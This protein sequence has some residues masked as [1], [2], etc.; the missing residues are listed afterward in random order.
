[1]NAAQDDPCL[2]GCS[3]DNSR[4]PIGILAHDL[5][6]AGKL[7]AVLPVL[8]KRWRADTLNCLGSLNGV[9]GQQNESAALC[10][11]CGLTSRICAA[12]ECVP[13]RARVIA[14][15][16]FQRALMGCMLM[17]CVGGLEMT[18]MLRPAAILVL[19]A[20]LSSSGCASSSWHLRKESD[21]Q[22]YERF[23]RRGNFGPRDT[24][25]GLGH[26]P[27]IQPLIQL[28][29]QSFLTSS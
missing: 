12:D 1:M 27:L 25:G 3:F 9:L 20:L 17:R 11:L 10:A 2:A 18:G 16:L 29:H 21:S 7:G 5:A 4:G 6:P 15:S 23:W 19:L 24:G 13:N 26:E 14:V 8:L 28:T 22:Y